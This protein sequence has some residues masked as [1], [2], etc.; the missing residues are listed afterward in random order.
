MLLNGSIVLKITVLLTGFYKRFL[1]RHG[2]KNEFSVQVYSRLN[3][4]YIV[5]VWK[6]NNRERER[7]ERISCTLFVY[8]NRTSKERENDGE[9]ITS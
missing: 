3:T 5:N 4:D 7:E 6:K 2:V 9:M 8:E 1:T